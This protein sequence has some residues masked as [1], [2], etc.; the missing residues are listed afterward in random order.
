MAEEIEKFLELLNKEGIHNQ[1]ACLGR[2]YLPRDDL[3]C[4][5][6]GVE[7]RSELM[8]R[9]LHSDLVN[10]VRYLAGGSS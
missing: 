2:L 3:E 7:Q 6:H 8:L 5:L 1:L 10:T 4:G 9:Q